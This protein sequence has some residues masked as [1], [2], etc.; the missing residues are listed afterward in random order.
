MERPWD[1]SRAARLSPA[2]S[3]D[4]N[5]KNI[6]KI[7]DM[8]NAAFGDVNEKAK[9]QAALVGI[10]QGNKTLAAFLPKW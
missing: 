7:V 4:I 8:L 3:G 6:Q 9:S 10:V 5:F 1:E 2:I